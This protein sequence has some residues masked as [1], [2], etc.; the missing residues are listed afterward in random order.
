MQRKTKEKKSCEEEMKRSQT[1]PS[2]KKCPSPPPRPAQPPSRLVG[3]AVR[4]IENK[5]QNP[6]YKRNCIADS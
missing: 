1:W 4:V 6:Y 3:G 5:I 2:Q